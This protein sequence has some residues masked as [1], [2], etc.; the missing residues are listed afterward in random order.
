LA[1]VVQKVVIFVENTTLSPTRLYL[2]AVVRLILVVVEI[3]FSFLKTVQVL[4]LTPALLL[5]D[6]TVERIAL[7]TYFI[8][9][10]HVAS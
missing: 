10:L 1:Y 9:T 4:N 3:H 6:M 2:G 7:K 8:A 5:F